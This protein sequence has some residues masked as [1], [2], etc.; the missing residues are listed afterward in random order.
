MSSAVTPRVFTGTSSQDSPPSGA[1]HAAERPAVQA[2]T[3]LRRSQ[4]VA[5]APRSTSVTV[6]VSAARGL[7]KQ[8]FI[9]TCTAPS[10]G[11]ADLPRDFP[12]EHLYGVGQQLAVPLRDASVVTVRFLL[13]QLTPPHPNI[14]FLLCHGPVSTTSRTH[15]PSSRPRQ[16]ACACRGAS[17]GP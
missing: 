12:V 16:A 1:P 9:A 7:L 13:V 5:A 3:V 15:E 6:P 10:A 8:S 2:R 17:R 4:V 11:C 14:A